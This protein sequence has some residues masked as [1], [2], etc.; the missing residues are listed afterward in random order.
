M[1]DEARSQIARLRYGLGWRLRS[2]AARGARTAEIL[3]LS[4]RESGTALPRTAARAAALVRRRGFTLDE[5]F[6]LGLLDPDRPDEEVT[7]TVSKREM[8]REQAR[9]NPNEFWYLT[10]DKAIFYRHA[11]AIGLPVP[12][13]YAILCQSGPGWSHTGAQLAEPADWDGLFA[14]GLPDT[15]VIKPARGYYGLDVRVIER[16]GDRLI[17]LGAG[18]VT[19]SELRRQLVDNRQFHVHVVQER[20]TNH[21][22]MP[23]GRDALQT[24]RMVTLVD[25][26]GSVH[27]ICGFF[28]TA[29]SG[30]VI[31]NFR[32]GLTGNL[33]SPVDPRDGTFLE[34][35]AAGPGGVLR[36]VD[37]PPG[38]GA[39]LPGTRM[40]MWDECRAAVI[41]AASA[42]LP[43]RTL[44]WDVAV[45]PEG[46]RIVEA[47]MWWDPVGHV[48]GVYDALE[49]LKRA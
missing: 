49:Q 46:V 8:I 24:V 4:A 34:L 13:L 35:I 21:A 48:E 33:T 14:H 2:G 12:T 20:L 10:E 38:T 25:R 22:D 44:G 9:L 42:F 29:L 37:P 19:P 26:D 15:F 23:G 27:V 5:A 30:A 11:E 3:R 43:M 1:I 40:P 32:L 47:N 18:E 7:R 28:K 36:Q 39:P 41:A 16:R 31:D 17:Q 6:T 45:T